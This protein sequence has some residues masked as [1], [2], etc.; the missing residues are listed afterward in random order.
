MPV[1]ERSALV[2]Y[3]AEQMYQ[4]VDS[5]TS[6]PE[7]VPWCV[8]ADELSRGADSVDARLKVSKGPLQNSF[9][10]RNSL[11]PFEQI[12]ME[13]LDGP[14]RHLTGC[15]TFTPLREDACKITLNL[16]FEFSNRTADVAFGRLFGEIMAS[17]IDAFT[18]QA[19]K[20]YGDLK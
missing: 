19:A 20:Q 13:L 18:K 2:A 4:L 8:A 9:T 14:F 5:I 11:Q 17:M 7:F 15:W 6:Y 3:S 16:D 10:T 12:S 1:V